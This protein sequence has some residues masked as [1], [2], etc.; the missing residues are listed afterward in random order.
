[1]KTSTMAFGSV[2]TLAVGAL[3]LG[4]LPLLTSRTHG[5]TSGAPWGSLT[6][7]GKSGAPTAET[8]QSGDQAKLATLDALVP[9]ASA[10]SQTDNVAASTEPT[11]VVTPV[12]VISLSGAQTATVAVVPLPTPVTAQ[13]TPA[14]QDSTVAT[15]RSGDAPAA[16]PAESVAALTPE[17]PAA[18]AVDPQ[19]KGGTVNINTAS[20]DVLDH[21]P[22]LGRIG[23]AIVSHRPYRS[24]NDL[25]AKRVLRSSD[26]H[27]LQSHITVD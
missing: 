24:A 5:S 6:S 17:T 4:V 12:R 1:M 2:S 8:A 18:D 25:L 19:A 26:F 16:A 20:I 10:A 13:A 27:K 14:S 15:V 22:G 11:P 3:L 7:E 9:A 21:M 23:K